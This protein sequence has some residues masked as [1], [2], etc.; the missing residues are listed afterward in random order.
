MKLFT[1][2]FL[3]IYAKTKIETQPHKIKLIYNGEASYFDENI[4]LILPKVLMSL[5]NDIEKL[6]LILKPAQIHIKY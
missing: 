3:T 1:L 4:D 5:D 2:F 6:L